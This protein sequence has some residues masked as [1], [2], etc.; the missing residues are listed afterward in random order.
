MAPKGAV[1][2]GTVLKGIIL[3]TIIT[4]QE[5]NDFYKVLY[6]R[7]DVRSEFLPDSVADEV[8]ERILQAAH[9]A[10]SV[11]FSQPW[12]FILLRDQQIK[13]SI[14]RLHQEANAEAA[15][16][17]AD[18][19][20]QDYRQIKLA[21]IL[22]AP[23]NI[24]ITCDRERGGSVVLGKTHQPEMDIYSTVCA[25]QNLQLAARAE[26]IGVGWVSIMDKQKLKS[27]L[28]IPERIEVVAYL[29]IGHVSQFYD[30]PEL[31]VKGWKDRTDL[32]GLVSTDQWDPK[33]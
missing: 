33:N 20:Q 19:R 32:A 5:R 9:H 18:K 24:C 10:P 28:K 29:C 27:L 30:E 26:N 11:G 16:M 1:F 3:N 22:D 17:F 23:I 14:H 2:K 13:Q 31:Q 25:V 6:G 15:E 8:L 7:R 21:G 12:N 4:Q